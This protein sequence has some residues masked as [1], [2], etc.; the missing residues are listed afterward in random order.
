M[1][2]AC[3]VVASTAGGAPEAI[4]DGQTG[5][6]V[7]PL[8]V[9]AVTAALDLILGDASLR[10]RMGEAGRRRVENYFAMDKYILR[11]LAAYRKAI[12]CS[13]S[14]LHEL[15]VAKSADGDHRH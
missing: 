4:A 7:P 14:K 15:K 8:D 13:R 1:A 2:C 9:E 12:D 3:P 11:V 10:R 5:I 6:L